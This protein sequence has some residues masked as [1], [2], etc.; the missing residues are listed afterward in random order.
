MR[1]TFISIGLMPFYYLY[2]LFNLDVLILESLVTN[3]NVI[4]Q[5][6]T[7]H[8]FWIPGSARGIPQFKLV[9]THWARKPQKWTLINMSKMPKWFLSIF[10][11]S[12][13]C[14]TTNFL[15]KKFDLQMT[16]YYEKTQQNILAFYFRHLGREIQNSKMITLPYQCSS[17]YF[18]NIFFEKGILEKV[19]W[20][21][22]K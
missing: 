14:A 10:E 3:K 21:M 22:K 19:K 9:F 6:V 4:R 8:F 17:S 13:P 15:I 1:Y 5:N 16:F 12:S 11:I 20:S 2:S 18:Q 7:I